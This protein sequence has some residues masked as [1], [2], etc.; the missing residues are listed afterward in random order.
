MLIVLQIVNS[1]NL[2]SIQNQ[3]TWLR[4]DA[5]YL[6]EKSGILLMFQFIKFQKLSI[7]EIPKIFNL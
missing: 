3:E 2:S 6:K 1:G 7:R 5:K 4:L